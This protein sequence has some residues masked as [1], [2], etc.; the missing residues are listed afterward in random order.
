M[1]YYF[2]KGPVN[3][4]KNFPDLV[5]NSFYSRPVT[6]TFYYILYPSPQGITKV[7][8]GDY[9]K[10]WQSAIVD[11]EVDSY[12][13]RTNPQA[14]LGEKVYEESWVP[15]HK[16]KGDDGWL[17]IMVQEGKIIGSY[18]G[19]VYTDDLGRKFSR[20]SFITISPEYEGRGLCREFATFT[21]E[22]LLSVY[23]VDYIVILVASTIR[24]GACRCYVR[25]AKDLG[26]YVFGKS[27]PSD[28]SGRQ[29]YVYAEPE[30][31]QL[32][33]LESLIFTIHP[34]LDEVM[35]RIPALE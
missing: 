31:C 27:P 25:A 2:Y 21:Y 7:E 24:A 19:R 18:V 29:E 30:D 11:R 32:Y 12:I 13:E 28:T 35:E 33:D 22:R 15:D 23:K 4:K 14:F 26:L 3:L 1:R 20:K 6:E 16:T 10:G 17:S 9:G 34:V 8:V 5:N